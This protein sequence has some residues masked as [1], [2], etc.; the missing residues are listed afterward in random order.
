MTT[1]VIAYGIAFGMFYALGMYSGYQ[2]AKKRYRG[3]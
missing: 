2:K 1:E 3:F